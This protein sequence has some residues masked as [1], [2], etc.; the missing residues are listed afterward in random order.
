M[1][2]DLQGKIGKELEFG[3]VFQMGRIKGNFLFILEST[4]IE[5]NDKTSF[6]PMLEEHANYSEKEIFRQQQQTRDV[7]VRKI[8]IN[9]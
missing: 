1:F 2:D 4:S 7:G 3:R 8:G 6:I 9:C 5:M